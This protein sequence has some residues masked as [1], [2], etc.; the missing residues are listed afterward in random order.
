MKGGTQL[1]QTA[2]RVSKI[3]VRKGCRP[4]TVEGEYSLKT[5]CSHFEHMKSTL[6][7]VGKLT[8]TEDLLN[9]LSKW[10]QMSVSG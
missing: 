8:F 1:T 5:P 4:K 6:G 3:D 2:V 9:A 10:R 7:P